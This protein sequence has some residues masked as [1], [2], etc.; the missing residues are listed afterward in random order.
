MNTSLGNSLDE[1]EEE[2]ADDVGEL[3]SSVVNQS[4]LL[5]RHLAREKNN[6]SHLLLFVV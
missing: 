2:E 1:E 3:A 4:F 6:G 5:Q